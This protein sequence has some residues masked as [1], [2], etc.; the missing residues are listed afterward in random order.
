MPRFTPNIIRLGISGL[1]LLSAI[2]VYL[3]L[4]LEP[5]VLLEPFQ[6]SEKWFLSNA[7]MFGSAPSFFYTLSIGLLVGAVSSNFFAARIHCLAWTAIALLLELA[8][9]AIFADQ[10]TG[11]LVKL[12]PETVMKIIGPYWTRG[13]FDPLDLLATFIGGLLALVILSWLRT[14]ADD[15][16]GQ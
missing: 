12:L 14:E 8:Q 16:S 1:S 4:R 2:A 15:S 11:F 6:S 5:P 7:A 9:H 10:V 3:F 13:I